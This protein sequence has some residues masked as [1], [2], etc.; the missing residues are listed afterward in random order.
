MTST[1]VKFGKTE[2]GAVWLDAQKTP[3][4]SFYQYWVNTADADAMQYLRL[5]TAADDAQLA[6]LES[7]ITEKPECRAAQLYLAKELTTLIHGHAETERAIQASKILFGE[8]F[9]DVDSK[10]LLAVFNDV[11]STAVSPQ[12]ISEGMVLQDLLV[13]CGIATS[14]GAARRSID[15]GG[16]YINNERATDPNTA[17]TE[18]SFVDGSVLVLRSGKKNYHLVRM[19]NQ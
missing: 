15:G 10:T 6:S 2:R 3:P 8:K 12:N 17:I 9:T 11:P 14:K 18:S 16:V 1:G 7:A 19:Q 13:Q 5:F 4:Y